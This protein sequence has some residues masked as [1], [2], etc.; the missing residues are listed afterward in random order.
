MVLK[1][2][3][4]RYLINQKL[5]VAERNITAFTIKNEG[6]ATVSVPEL[7]LELLAGDAYS[8]EYKGVVDANIQSFS[9]DFSGSGEKKCR[10]VLGILQCDIIDEIC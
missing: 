2:F 6:E 8:E 5:K 9:F 4:K 3:T 7:S 1:G 10:F